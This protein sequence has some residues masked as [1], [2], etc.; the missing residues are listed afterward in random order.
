MKEE[1]VVLKHNLTTGNKEQ[2]MKCEI[3]R[4]GVIAVCL[5]LATVE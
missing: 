3:A 4:R 5:A 2:T 1:S